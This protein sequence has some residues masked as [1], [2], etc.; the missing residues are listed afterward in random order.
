[1][2]SLLGGQKL[3]QGFLLPQGKE[4]VSPI[5]RSGCQNKKRSIAAAKP[6]LTQQQHASRREL[7]VRAV[8]TPP[9]SATGAALLPWQVNELRGGPGC[10]RIEIWMC[11][12]ST[13]GAP[14]K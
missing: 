12:M 14:G 11:N 8:E 10:L 13:T 3:A 2:A 7:S 4:S 6:V 9:S 5:Q 1:M